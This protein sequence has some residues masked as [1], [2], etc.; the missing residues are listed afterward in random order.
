MLLAPQE[1]Q[2]FFRLHRSLMCFV[3]QRLG[4][5]PDIATPEQFGA[6]VPAA[7]YDVRQAFLKELG[8]I[9][10]FV[11]ANPYHLT[12]EELDI[13]L[14][15]RHQVAGKFFIFRYLQKYAIFLAAEK[16][17]VAYGVL[18]L[19]EPLE[20]V[21]GPHL[22]FLAETM[23]LPFRGQIVYDGLIGG[24]NVSFGPGIRRQSADVAAGSQRPDAGHSP[25]PAGS[26]GGGF[27]KRPDSLYPR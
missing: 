2:L 15:W 12:E 18:A 23:L 27:R 9:E 3:N 22:P 16:P 25:L 11:E 7:R 10:R 8:L 26:T 21:I 13:V 20:D 24:Y 19:T 1:A 6:L 14:S 5:V 17:P 4:V